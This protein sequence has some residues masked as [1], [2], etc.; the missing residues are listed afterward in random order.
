MN[1]FHA[2]LF[3]VPIIA[4]AVGYNGHSAAT[5]VTSRTNTSTVSVAGDCDRQR[6]AEGTRSSGI[7]LAQSGD[8]GK[9]CVRVGSSDVPAKEE[10]CPVDVYAAEEDVKKS[11]ERLCIIDAKTG[12]TLF[13]NR[14][15][16]EAMKRLKKS[17]CQCGADAVIITGLDRESLFSGGPGWG[18]S[19]VKA[20]GIRYQ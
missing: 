12:S 5:N 14:S 7:L 1:K 10:G 20:I 19:G 2:T 17:A 4:I 8:C 18:R 15:S 16:E 9:G 13:H 6:L 11:F 3:S